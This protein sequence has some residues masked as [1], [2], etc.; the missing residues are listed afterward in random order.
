MD[1]S[2]QD[3]IRVIRSFLVGLALGFVVGA[4]TGQALVHVLKPSDLL[5][6]AAIDTRD[7]L[8]QELAA[9][10]QDALTRRR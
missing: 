3:G 1:S 8:A 5:P 9:E 10:L 6:R 4:M 2:G 7:A